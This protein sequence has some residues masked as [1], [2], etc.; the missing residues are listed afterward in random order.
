M[1]YILINKIGLSYRDLKHISIAEANRLITVHSEF[2]IYKE[3][4][5][6]KNS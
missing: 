2:E 4:Q 6:D 5:I 1:K 3:E